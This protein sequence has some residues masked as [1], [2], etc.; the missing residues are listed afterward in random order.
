[1][2]ANLLMKSTE[3]AGGAGG[4]GVPAQLEKSHMF[5]NKRSA[6]LGTCCHTINPAVPEFK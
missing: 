5:N 3:G 6:L 2:R 4:A 1:M